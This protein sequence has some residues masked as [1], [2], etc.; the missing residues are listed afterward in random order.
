M[1]G[2]QPTFNCLSAGFQTPHLSCG[3]VYGTYL[4]R[5][6]LRRKRA[7]VVVA[8]GLAVGIALVVTVSSVSRGMERAQDDVLQSL[9]GL[10]TDMTVTKPPAAAAGAAG[11]RGHGFGFGAAGGT[12]TQSADRV[13]MQGGLQGLD[14]GTV[15][16]VAKQEGVAE[17][18]AGLALQ[19]LRV[20]GRFEQGVIVEDPGGERGA[21]GEE[22]EAPHARR[23]RV[24]GGGAQFDVNNFTVYGVDE[25]R[26]DLGP[27]ASL[28]VTAGSG[29]TPTTTADANVAVVDSAYAT[30]ANVAVGATI[31]V[32]GTPLKV[33][34]LVTAS[35][36]SS[37]ANVYVPLRAAQQLTGTPGQIS[38]IFVKVSD[39]TRLGTTKSAVQGI[40]PG[41]TVTTS[42]DL[43]QTVSGSLSTA[44]D[45]T[46]RVGRWLSVT[47]LA[48]AFIVAALLTSAAVTRRVR[49]FGTLKALGWSS[50]RV[51]RQVMAEALV[52]G[53][54]G[55]AIGIALGVGAAYLISSRSATLTAQ[56]GGAGEGF[57]EAAVRSVA[58]SLK[59]PVSGGTVAVAVALAVAGGLVSGM[60]GGWRAARLRPAEALRRVD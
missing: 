51:T 55:G 7:A 47:V 36:G 24:E 19:V 31:T 1:R 28:A 13:F 11:E 56:L 18:S 60:Y 54:L 37:V 53:L 3:R 38:T 21:A 44:R 25:T 40:V 16:T 22:A 2:A 27:I 4:R 48:A 33:I 42:E 20:S 52:N 50:G 17:A 41:A 12:A 15:G 46:N 59:A 26:P 8:L 29:L 34:G 49:E 14:A 43:A 5:E 32:N 45:L 58:V 39:S 9:Y 35:R 10:G 6:L 23:N 30:Q 57:R